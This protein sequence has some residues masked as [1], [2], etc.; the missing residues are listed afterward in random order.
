MGTRRNPTN[1]PGDSNNVRLKLERLYDNNAR[2]KRLVMRGLHFAIVD[3]ADSV[4]VDEART[5]LIISGQ[6]DPQDE[7]RNA[8]LAFEL[9]KSFKRDRDYKILADEKRVRVAYAW[10]E[11]SQNSHKLNIWNTL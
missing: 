4:L 5:P 10:R 7:E 3:E 2:S 9:V 8:Q 6:T 1:L 11:K